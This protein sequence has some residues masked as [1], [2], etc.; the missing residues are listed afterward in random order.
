[1]LPERIAQLEGIGFCWNINDVLW[2]EMFAAMEK[3]RALHGHCIVPRSD[4]TVSDSGTGLGFWINQQR[5]AK[6]R[7]DQNVGSRPGPDRD[8]SIPPCRITPERIGRLDAVG[9]TWDVLEKA[10]TDKF[11]EL[12]ACSCNPGPGPVRAWAQRQRKEMLHRTQQGKDYTGVMSEDRISKLD[13]IGF[14]WHSSR[15]P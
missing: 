4:A 10:W 7:Y 1:M 13:S 14:S 2:E 15:T 6:R 5:T 9:F 8:K 11:E 12:K 3:Y